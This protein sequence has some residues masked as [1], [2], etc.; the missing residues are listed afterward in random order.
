M[1][2][3]RRLAGQSLVEFALIISLMIFMLTFFLDISRAAYYNSALNNA[4]REGTRYAMV[5]Q[6]VPGDPAVQERVRQYAIGLDKSVS[7]LHIDVTLPEDPTATPP[8]KAGSQV[9]IVATYQFQP[10]TPGLSQILGAGNRITLHVQ[11]IVEVAPINI[12]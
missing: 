7:V 9:K 6:V 12:P 11:S 5:H 10:A 4:V 2:P 8:I 1:N 3:P